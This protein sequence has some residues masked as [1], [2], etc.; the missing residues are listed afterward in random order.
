[1]KAF[2]FDSGLSRQRAF[3]LDWRVTLL[4]MKGMYVTFGLIAFCSL[5]LIACLAGKKHL[6]FG[7]TGTVVTKDSV[8]GTTDR[9]SYEEWTKALQTDDKVTQVQ[10]MVHGKLV[11]LKPGTKIKVVASY[12]YMGTHAY[13]AEMTQRFGEGEDESWTMAL[14]V[15]AHYV[16]AVK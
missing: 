9:E 12:D 14:F 10:L 1:L 13:K 3:N 7:E 11:E 15:N 16:D 5:G 6:A 4:S 2:I 8:Y